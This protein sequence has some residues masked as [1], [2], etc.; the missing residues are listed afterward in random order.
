MGDY[1][2]PCG[3]DGGGHEATAGAVYCRFAAAAAVAT[4]ATAAPVTRSS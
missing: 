4:P 3:W 2:W 1:S